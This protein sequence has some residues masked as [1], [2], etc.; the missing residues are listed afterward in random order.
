MVSKRGITL[1]EVIVTI[2]VITVLIA[3]ALPAIQRA[4]G[5]A[6]RTSCSSNL[7]QILLA[8][9]SFV[10]TEQSLPSLF[11]GTDLPYP[12]SVWDQ[13]HAHSWR[14]PLLPH[15]ELQ[16]LES[17]V[18]WENL[19]TEPSNS[20]VAQTVVTT[21]ICPSGT[22]PS[23]MGTGLRHQAIG[24]PL[25]ERSEQDYY[26][27]VRADYDAMAGIHVVPDP[28][29]PDWIPTTVDSVRWGVWGRASLDG[30]T[31]GGSLILSFQRGKFRDV[32]DGLSNTI[33]VVERGG[34][35]VELR[36]GKPF[37]TDDNPEANYQ[38]QS[39]WSPSN[40]FQ[41]AINGA[42]FGINVSNSSGIYSL[43]PGG[44]NVAFADGSVKF[45]SESTS[46]DA[47]ATFFGR[48]DGEM[49]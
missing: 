30:E 15:L 48:A 13:F 24:K 21:F 18:V 43:H 3:I 47:L 28:I 27:V 31:I 35:P 45:L 42:G 44:A 40:S 5:T 25:E 7:R 16:V 8:T 14:V 17:Q 38:G 26:S 10:S 1:L 12:L 34:R 37:V 23:V 9:H 49:E 20:K 22:D 11:N 32:F 19:A 46:V 39:G 41:M 36:H 6:K 33:A 2:G 29:P 4:R